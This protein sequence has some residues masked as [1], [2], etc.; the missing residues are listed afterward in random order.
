[1]LATRVPG[2]GSRSASRSS[3]ANVSGSSSL[4]GRV[5]DLLAGTPVLLLTATPI[6]N[7]LAELGLAETDLVSG[8]ASG[9]GAP[10]AAATSLHGP[11]QV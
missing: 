5:K 1:M 7:S 2:W 6:Q 3:S 10:V 8:P 4:A 9:N 11:L